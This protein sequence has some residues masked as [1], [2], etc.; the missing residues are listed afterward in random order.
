MKM[1]EM[2]TEGSEHDINSVDR[3]A[4]G[5]ERLDSNFERSFVVSKVL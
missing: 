4:A 2:T 3:A 5:F 1:L